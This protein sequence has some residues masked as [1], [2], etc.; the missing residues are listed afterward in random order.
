[1]RRRGERGFT[2][3]E[4]AIATAL[5]SFVVLAV[6]TAVVH[7]L[8]A[9]ATVAERA[10]LTDDAL[11]VLADLRSATAYDADALTR[12]AGRTFAASVVRDGQTLA[13]GVSV[14]GGG[15]SGPVT[16][17]VTVTDA[18]GTSATETRQLYVEAPAPGSVIDQPSPAPSAVVP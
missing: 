15:A 2:L 10:A 14:T 4:A 18:N 1:M 16:A 7:S 3:L 12:I 6:S 17:A 11:N 9:T 8:H 5:V 13:V